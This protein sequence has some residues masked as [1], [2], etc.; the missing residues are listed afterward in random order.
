MT[1]LRLLNN[2]EELPKKRKF[3]DVA[4][5]IFGVFVPVWNT[6]YPNEK[7]RMTGQDARDVKEFLAFNPDI[8]E[9]FAEAQSHAELYIKDEFEAWVESRHPVWGFVKHYNRYIP[10]KKRELPKTQYRATFTCEHCGEQRGL[11]GECEHCHK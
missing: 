2:E 4:Q 1:Q 6:R 8:M 10:K 11:Y 5:F 3:N 7:Y 9:E